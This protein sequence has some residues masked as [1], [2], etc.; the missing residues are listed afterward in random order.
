M[1][2]ASLS[3]MEENDQL[4]SPA[5]LVSNIILPSTLR[6]SKYH[7]EH[8]LPYQNATCKFHASYLRYTSPSPCQ[9]N[10]IRGLEL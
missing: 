10:Y 9:P 3:Q 7:Y 5:N 2:P 6:F 4:H 8:G 1:A